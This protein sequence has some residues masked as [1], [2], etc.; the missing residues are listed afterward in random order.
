MF[1]ILFFLNILSISVEIFNDNIIINNNAQN[2][3]NNVLNEN[4]NNNMND[5]FKNVAN[6]S[7]NIAN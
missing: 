4:V 6:K 7:F 1:N 2:S 5:I 3:T